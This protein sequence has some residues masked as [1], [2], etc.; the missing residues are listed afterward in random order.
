MT[1]KQEREAQTLR[2]MERGAQISAAAERKEHIEEMKQDGTIRVGTGLI[3]DLEYTTVTMGDKCFTELS[4]I[5][6]TA[7]LYANMLLCLEF[8]YKKRGP[9][10]YTGPMGYTGPIGATEFY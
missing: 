3:D 1:P 9:M 6:P 7:T 2:E 4:S 10:W 5:F 8:V